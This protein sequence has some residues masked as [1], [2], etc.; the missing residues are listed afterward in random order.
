MGIFNTLSNAYKNGKKAGAASAQ[1]DI[2]LGKQSSLGK[3]MAKGAGA[4]LK[5]EGPNIL[6]TFLRNIKF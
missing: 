2:N 6:R 1:K 4:A 5:A 3:S